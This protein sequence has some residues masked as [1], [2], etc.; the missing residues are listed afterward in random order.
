MVAKNRLTVPLRLKTPSPF[1]IRW[2]GVISSMLLLR[3][4]R[5]M[6]VNIVWVLFLYSKSTPVLKFLYLNA[7]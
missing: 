4:Y 6:P 2:E 5:I 1:S 7:L 3:S